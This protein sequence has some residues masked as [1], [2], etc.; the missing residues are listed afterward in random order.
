MSWKQWTAVLVVIGLGIVLQIPRHDGD[1]MDE[2]T[3]TPGGAASPTESSAVPVAPEPAG[4]YRTM[5][6]E[7]TGMT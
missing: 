4:P 5:V 2:H 6:L 7:V 1:T 3:H